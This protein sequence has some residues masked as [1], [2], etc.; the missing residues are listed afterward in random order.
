MIRLT[1]LYNLPEGTDEEQFLEWRLGEHQAY[2]R[3]MPDVVRTD[4]GRIEEGW[5][6]GVRPPHRFMTTADWPD[7]ESFRKG[8]YDPQ[9]QADLRENVK[10]IA[11]PVFLVSEILA[12][13]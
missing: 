1:V 2:N 5:P 11:D 3:S 7:W 9:V 13:G 12:E 8:F 4:F 10:R 6:E